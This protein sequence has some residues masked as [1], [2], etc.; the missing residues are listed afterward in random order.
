MNVQGRT[1]SLA[2]GPRVTFGNLILQADGAKGLGERGHTLC[3]IIIMVV[4]FVV[5]TNFVVFFGNY[6]SMPLCGVFNRGAFQCSRPSVR[7]NE[8]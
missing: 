8:T 3:Q 5:M 1:V 6:P 7:G 4:L 2:P